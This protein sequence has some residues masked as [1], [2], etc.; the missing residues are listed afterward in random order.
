MSL[1]SPRNFLVPFQSR[2]N[3]GLIIVVAVLVAAIRLAGGGVSVEKDSP[4]PRARAAAATDESALRTRLSEESTR[5]RP[6]R[7]SSQA[8]SAGRDQL[9]DDLIS[10]EELPPSSRRRDV[11]QPQ[12]KQANEL[13]DIRKS[14]GLE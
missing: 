6:S 7:G 11:R 2:F 1:I 3:I 5:E 9:L 10:G 14:L 4:R 13:G 12:G 8:A